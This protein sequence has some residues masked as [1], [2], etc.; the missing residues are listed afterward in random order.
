MWWV[1]NKCTL[2]PWNQAVIL[3]LLGH[4]RYLLWHQGPFV[5]FVLDFKGFLA[6]R[7]WKL[8]FFGPW[9]TKSCTFSCNWVIFDV[10]I[11]ERVHTLSC[12]SVKLLIAFLRCGVSSVMLNNR[13]LYSRLLLLL[14]ELVFQDWS[15]GLSLPFLAN[16][17]LLSIILIGS[18]LLLICPFTIYFRFLN[19]L[20]SLSILLLFIRSPCISISLE[21]F[22]LFQ[23]RRLIDRQH[24]LFKRCGWVFSS[25]KIHV[26]QVK[27]LLNWNRVV[28]TSQFPQAR[29]K[30]GATHLSH[31]LLILQNFLDLRNIVVSYN[32]LEESWNYWACKGC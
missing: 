4:A 5:S 6:P 32:Y 9:I 23:K 17:I 2:V 27:I 15:D 31:L 24:F 3:L 1:F 13:S 19:R 16:Q 29:F 20:C 26:L 25:F 21:V 11:A 12:L 10:F 14:Q 8:M 30:L 28:E 7:H 18:N 22:Q